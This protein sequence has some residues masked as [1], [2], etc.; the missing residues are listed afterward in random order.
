MAWG[1]LAGV[2]AGVEGLQNVGPGVCVVK[3]KNC[4]NNQMRKCQQ[5]VTGLGWELGWA[6]HW[7]MA[8]VQ[9]VNNN[10]G[11][12]MCKVFLSLNAQLVT[13]G[14]RTVYS[15]MWAQQRRTVKVM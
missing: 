15:K 3:N 9:S 11:K 4:S 13:M 1:N 5:G 10:Q 12:G 2:G 8:W 7:V 14:C 6:L